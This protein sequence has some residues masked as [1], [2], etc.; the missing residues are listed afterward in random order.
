MIGHCMGAA[1]AIEAIASVLTIGHGVIHPALN[2]ETP[3]PDCDLDYVPGAAREQP[4]RVVLSNSFGL[5][6]RDACLV[7]ASVE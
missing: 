7:L 4:V 1:C 5:D 2:Y 6:G 3:D